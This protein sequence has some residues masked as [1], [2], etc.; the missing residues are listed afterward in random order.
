MAR[1]KKVADEATKEK[2]SRIIGHRTVPIASIDAFKF[3]NPRKMRARMTDVLDNSLREFGYVEP[4]IVREVNG[5]FEILNGHHRYDGMKRAGEEAIEVTIVDCP[6]DQ[7][8]K[9]LTLALNR[10]SADWDKDALDSYVEGILSD[11]MDAR[12][13]ADVTGFS[14]A[15]VDALVEANTNFLDEFVQG[16]GDAPARPV[17]SGGTG[18]ATGSQLPKAKELEHF[19]VYLNPEQQKVVDTAVAKAKSA[20]KGPMTTADALAR[21]CSTFLGEN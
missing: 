5:R 10:I 13:I 15:E 3:G 2:L 11:S 17:E 7:R 18:S 12:W 14:G 8:A 9:A 21:I 6:D 4:I 20:N 1:A 16:G 19:T